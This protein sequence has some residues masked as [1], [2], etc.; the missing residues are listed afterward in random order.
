MVGRIGEQGTKPW[1]I[2]LQPTKSSLA[3]MPMSVRYSPAGVSKVEARNP[4]LTEDIE[5]P[6]RQVALSHRALWRRVPLQA[7]LPHLEAPVHVCPHKGGHLRQPR[8]V[9]PLRPVGTSP[10]V[11]GLATA[12]RKGA[13]S[14]VKTGT[15]SPRTLCDVSPI[16]PRACF[17][18]PPSSPHRHDLRPR[19]LPQ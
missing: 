17:G 16:H 8:A 3:R 5:N 4:T 13:M 10:M 7:S 6:R 14:M 12:A 2:K 18:T 11:R 15:T 19:D 9:E 1:R